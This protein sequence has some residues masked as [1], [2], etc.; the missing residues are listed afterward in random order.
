LQKKQQFLFLLHF[1]LTY[2]VV[3]HKF[4]KSKKMAPVLSNLRFMSKCVQKTLN[5]VI[6]QTLL[7]GV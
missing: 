3:N 1:Y 6:G 4:K 5:I 7:V 2:S